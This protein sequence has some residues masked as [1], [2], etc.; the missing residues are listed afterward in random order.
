FSVSLPVSSIYKYVNPAFDTSRCRTEGEAVYDAGHVIECAVETVRGDRIYLSARV[1]QT[2]G[3]TSP[4]HNVAVVIEQKE[5]AEARC[6]CKAGNYKCKHV[7]AVL[8]HVNNEKSLEQLSATD[9]PQQWG[10]PQ[11]EKLKEEYEPRKIVDLP[12]IEKLKIKEPPGLKG[13]ILKR[14]LHNLSYRCAAQVHIDHPTECNPQGRQER[15]SAST[16]RTLQGV[17][18]GIVELA[19]EAGK[20]MSVE[21]IFKSLCEQHCHGDIETVEHATRG[22]SSNKLWLEHRIGMVTASVAYSVFTRV[23]TIRTKMG[24]HDVRALLRRLMRTKNVITPDMQ[25]GIRLEPEAKKCYRSKNTQ[26][27]DLHL[28]DRGLCVLQCKP[29]IG[30]SPDA[31]VTCACCPPR[32]LEVKCPRTL[33]MFVQSEVC[34]NAGTMRMKKTSKH[35]CQTQVQMGVIGITTTDIFVYVSDTE[36]MTIRVAFSQEYFDDVVERATF[37]LS[38]MFCHTCLSW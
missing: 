13:D 6:S 8:L 34:C 35:F 33:K 37:F 10:K 2:S 25:R 21:D 32:L 1:L 16:P 20:D 5:V 36:N 4:P 30:A 29:F 17:V 31:V 3:L 28:E 7:V 26:H 23:K 14:L 19:K 38:I 18:G 9:K 12:C 22:Q 15:K 27:T 11:K 24:P